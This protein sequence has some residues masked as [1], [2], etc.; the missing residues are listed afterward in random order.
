MNYG[1]IGKKLGH[2]YSKIIHEKLGNSQYILKEI[3]ENE[4]EL[5]FEKREFEAINVT[6]PYKKNA[7]AACDELSETAKAIGS[8]NVVIKR[9]DGTLYGDNTDAF[10]FEYMMDSAGIDP[11]GK[12]C[13]VLGSGGSSVMAQYVLKKRGAASVTV[14]SRSGEDNYENIA[15]HKDAEIIVNTTPVGMYPEN[16]VSAIDL[17]MFEQCIGVIDLIY[18][19][20]RTKLISD[21]LDRSIPCVSGLVMLVAQAKRAHELF[22]DKISDTDIMELT[23]NIAAGMKNI[24][25]V[26]MPGS[27]KSTIAKLLAKKTGRELIDTDDEI[28]KSEKRSIPD[29]FKNDGEAAFRAI[30]TKILKEVT[31]KSGC[32]IACGGGVVTIPE[33]MPLLRQNSTVFRIDRPLDQ[34]ATEGRPLSGEKGVK[35]LFEARDALYAK[36]ADYTIKFNSADAMCGEILKILGIEAK[37]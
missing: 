8:V 33:N 18:N 21:A 6:I 11:L 30:E 5:F 37:I 15:K 16:G 17:S 35:A 10:G 34:L 26:G 1:L 14:I 36:A 20:M 24:L 27:G 29:I 7:F 23:E 25:L 22:F 4:I 31:K 13:I 9:E 28:V 19:P 3:P 12:K 32:I 2:S